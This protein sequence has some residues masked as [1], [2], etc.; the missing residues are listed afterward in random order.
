MKLF[1]FL[2][3][4]FFSFPILAQNLP[5]NDIQSWNDI[6]VSKTLFKSTDKKG[7]EFDRVS[8]FFNGTLRVGNKVKTLIDERIGLGFDIKINHFLTLTPSYFYRSNKPTLN[9]REYESR[10]RFA[11]TFEKKWKRFSI[12]D[13]NLFEYRLRNSHPDSTRYRNKFTFTFPIMKNNKE[14]FAP[15]I[16]DEPFYDFSANRWSRNEI[17][18]GVSKKFT[19]NLSSDFYFLH[20]NNRTGTPKTVKSFGVSLKIKLD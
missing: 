5:R 19:K 2:L 20:Q 15:F 3:I 1:I 14:I 17:S 6:T 7:K 18:A 13:R 8:I 16:A 10:F 11:A 9:T 4:L 12:K